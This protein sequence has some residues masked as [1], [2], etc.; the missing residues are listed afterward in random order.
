MFYIC[1]PRSPPNYPGVTSTPSDGERAPLDKSTSGCRNSWPTED[2][3]IFENQQID[4]FNLLLLNLPM[5]PTTR[6]RNRNT[7]L[8]NGIIVR[9][10]ITTKKTRFFNAW[11]ER[12]PNKGL[13]AFYKR[14]T[15]PPSLAHR[16]LREQQVIGSPTYRRSRRRS[17]KLGRP[18]NIP[19][20]QLRILVSPS[21][22]PVRN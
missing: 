16:W 22:N 1:L 10:A 19:K 4:L 15:I 17:I 5:A 14:K 8:L 2:Y 7:P 3:P 21:K 13:N 12:L 11:D 6:L 18:F 20:E 9:E